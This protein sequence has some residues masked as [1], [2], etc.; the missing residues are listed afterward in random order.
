MV[1]KGWVRAARTEARREVDYV[2]VAWTL[3]G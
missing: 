2:F 3:N 1:V